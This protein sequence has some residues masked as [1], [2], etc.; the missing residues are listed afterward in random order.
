MSRKSRA[1]LA[2]PC[3]T[4]GGGATVSAASIRSFTGEFLYA[5]AALRRDHQ[6]GER[7]DEGV[8]PVGTF[9]ANVAGARHVEHL[10]FEHREAPTWQTLPCSYKDAMGSAR[11]ALPR[12]AVMVFTGTFAP[13]VRMTCSTMAP[14]KF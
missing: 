5:K 13:A 1:N 10:L 3:L 6:L 8:E 9:C 2:G 14:P 12:E 4:T 11:T 7:P